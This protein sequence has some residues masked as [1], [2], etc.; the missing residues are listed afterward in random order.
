MIQER[1]GTLFW[2]SESSIAPYEMMWKSNIVVYKIF[3]RIDMAKSFP[4]FPLVLWKVNTFN[5]FSLRRE[6]R[7]KQDHSFAQ[8]FIELMNQLLL[9]PIITPSFLYYL[10]YRHYFTHNYP[11]SLDPTL[12]TLRNTKS[13]PFLHSI[14]LLHC[15]DAPFISNDFAHLNKTNYENAEYSSGVFLASQKLNDDTDSV[16]G[17]TMDNSEAI[18][19]DLN[20]LKDP[21]SS[22]SV[23]A[24]FP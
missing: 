2:I 17:T 20:A 10:G 5:L 24:F 14:R 1:T 12:S 23:Q 19:V 6:V 21:L 11:S 3:R 7:K 9:F 18:K 13:R 15:R 16:L 8:T 4:C 22:I